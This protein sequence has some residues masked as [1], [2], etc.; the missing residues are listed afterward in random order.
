MATASANMF[1]HKNR[2]D[3]L[4][5]A[6]QFGHGIVLWDIACREADKPTGNKLS[7]APWMARGCGPGSKN[8]AADNNEG[9]QGIIAAV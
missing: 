8:L 4:L 2:Q 7:E 3:F 9:E 5:Y 6:G 1:G